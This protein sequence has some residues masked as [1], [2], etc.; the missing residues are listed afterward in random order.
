MRIQAIS[1]Q[2]N[3]LGFGAIKVQNG[4]LNN[5]NRRAVSDYIAEK[6][7]ETDPSDKSKRSFV[8][9]AE[10]YG[11]NILFTKGTK[12]NS[13]R[14]D[15][16]STLSEKQA[17]MH[18]GLPI[19]DDTCV[20]TYNKPEQFNIQHF[21]DKYIPEEKETIHMGNF[22]YGLLAVLVSLITLSLGYMIKSDILNQGNTTEVVSR[23]AIKSNS[24]KPILKDT[25]QLTKKAIKK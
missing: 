14:V 16:V 23:D 7:Y 6:L 17:A 4:I 25:L 11:Y 19:Y 5:E 3:Q 12:K 8:E 1:A 20:G 9:R 10:N 18:N 21:Y 13:V 24:V 22:Y 15:I 2:N